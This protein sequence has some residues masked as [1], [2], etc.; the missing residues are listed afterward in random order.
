VQCEI[1]SRAG[2]SG[3]RKSN[4]H[5]CREQ[6]LQLETG[7][8]DARPHLPDRRNL[9]HRT[10]G[11]YVWVKVRRTQC[12]YMFSALPSNPLLE[13]AGTSHL[14]HFQI[15]SPRQ[16]LTARLECDAI[17]NG[18][19]RLL[20]LASPTDADHLAIELFV[21]RPDG[22]RASC[23]LRFGCCRSRSSDLDRGW[24]RG[25][26]GDHRRRYARHRNRP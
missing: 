10:A 1:A 14:C 25:R 15:R 21:L 6:E 22:R 19:A 11:P 17:G 20:A 2:G 16:R 26:P 4:S 8:I 13:A 12:E 18:E 9:L 3:Q 7:Y 5:S 23:A 24:H